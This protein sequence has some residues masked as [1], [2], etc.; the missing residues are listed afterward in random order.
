V[1]QDEVKKSKHI[2]QPASDEVQPSP[3]RVALASF[4]D[5]V[6]GMLSGIGESHPASELGLP[7]DS[8]RLVDSPSVPSRT[9]SL[10]K[11]EPPINTDFGP[12][13]SNEATIRAKPD[14]S[15]IRLIHDTPL[16]TESDEE[17][18]RRLACEFLENDERSVASDKV[19]EY[20]GGP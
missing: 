17:K 15:S 6:S 1:I 2:R 14:Y 16:D 7:P 18:G 10:P 5:D 20:I 8:L 12:D 13:T 9:T 4:S 3:G 11:L 19:A